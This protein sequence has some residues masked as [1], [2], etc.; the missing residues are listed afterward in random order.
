MIIWLASYPKSGNT[1]IR[2]LLTSYFYSNDGVFN[3]NLLNKIE[4]FSSKNVPIQLND[5]SSYQTK[6]SKNWIP[7]QKII[8]DDKKVHLLKTHN[9]ICA[10]NGNNFTDKFNT[11]GAIYI[12]RDPR[13]LVTSLSHHYSLN[14]KEACDFITNKQ[15]IITKGE[16]GGDDFGIATVLGSWSQHYKSWKNLK[17]APILIIKYEDL[18]EDTKNSFIRIINFLNRFM[19]IKVDEKKI[20]NT[21]NNCQ[22]DKLAE[23]E[24]KEGFSENAGLLERVNNPIKSIPN[25]PTKTLDTLTLKIQAINLTYPH[26]MRG[27]R[28]R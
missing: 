9:A 7:A 14:I 12:V 16:W 23:L 24:K 11:I 8:N 17:F 1:W 10:I 27:L 26:P 4:Q 6:I 25:T 21:V 13:N 22:F 5:K 20:L 2:S 18:L 15:Q 28:I 19:D 3:F